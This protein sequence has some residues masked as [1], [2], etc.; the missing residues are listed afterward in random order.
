MLVVKLTITKVVLAMY[1]VFDL[2]IEQLSVNIIF[3]HGTLKQE[4][5]ML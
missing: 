5:Y 3:F 2:Y 1:V 4:I